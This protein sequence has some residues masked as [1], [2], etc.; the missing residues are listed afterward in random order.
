MGIEVIETEK[1]LCLSKRKYCLD[2]LVDFGLLACKPSVTPLKQNLSISNEPNVTDP[3]LDNITEYQKLIAKLIYLA[4]IKHDISYLV[5]CLSQFMH[6]PIRSHL[7]IAIKVLKYLKGLPG[8]DIHIV[9]CPNASLE[10]FVDVDWAKCFIISKFVT[11]F[12]LKVL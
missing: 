10:A 7:K 11:G 4:H 2:L 3:V 6:K 5:H 8:L 12:C 1:T 9:K